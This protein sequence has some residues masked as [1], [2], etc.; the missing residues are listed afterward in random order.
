MGRMWSIIKNNNNSNNNALSKT[1]PMGQMLPGLMFGAAYRWF[2]KNNSG[3]ML[4]IK[5]FLISAHHF[6]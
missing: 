6:D 5:V 2:D 1:G 4:Y 3:T